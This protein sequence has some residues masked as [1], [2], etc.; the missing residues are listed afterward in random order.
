LG[1]KYGRYHNLASVFEGAV[2]E[3]NVDNIS[4]VVKNALDNQVEMKEAAKKYSAGILN[5]PA[6]LCKFIKE[7][8]EK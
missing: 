4:E 5:S 7:N 6:D 8:I 2:L 1:V 3:S